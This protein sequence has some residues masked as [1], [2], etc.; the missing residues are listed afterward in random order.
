MP[1]FITREQMTEFF[2][3][4]LNH[5]SNLPSRRE[6]CEVAYEIFYYIYSNFALFKLHFSSHIKF[7]NVL[8][9]K[10]IEMLEEPIVAQQCPNLMDVCTQVLFKVQ[11][12]LL[13]HTEAM[14]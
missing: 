11:P 5:F 3:Q 2:A 13:E 12:I 8:A 4:R 1:G 6:K 9:K 14:G 10:C 7:M